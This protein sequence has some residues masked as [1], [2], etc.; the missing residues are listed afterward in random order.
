MLCSVR[1]CFES[2]VYY[3][4]WHRFWENETSGFNNKKR[5]AASDKLD[6]WHVTDLESGWWAEHLFWLLENS[7]LTCGLYLAGALPSC[8]SGCSVIFLPNSSFS[9]NLIPSSIFWLYLF[10][11]ILYVQHILALLK[12]FKKIHLMVWKSQPQILIFTLIII[13]RIISCS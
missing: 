11:K 4:V 1:M 9:L 5:C 8:T 12:A 3:V 2:I 6:F 10:S 13:S 7:H